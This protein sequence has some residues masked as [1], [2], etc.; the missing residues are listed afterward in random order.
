MKPVTEREPDGL[1]QLGTKLKLRTYLRELWSRRDFA[2][3]APLGDLRAQNMNSV[4]GSFWHLLNP[5]LLA[6]VYF[7][8]FGV[9]LG[10]RDDV[11]NFVAFLVIGIF[12]FHFTAKSLAGGS[13][14]VIA[15]LPL[16][17][18]MSFPRLVLPISAML[19]E[20]I[21]QVPAILTMFVIIAI[22]GEP[23][24]WLWLLVL[25]AFMLQSLF[26]F[27]LA[28][29]ISRLTFHFRDVQNLLPYAT[30]LLLYLSGVFYPAERIPAGT[31]RDLFEWNPMHVFIEVSRSLLLEQAVDP[32]YWGRAA[33]WTVVVAVAGFVF[34]RGKE[35]EY[36]RGY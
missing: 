31:A 33:L 19:T 12:I 11:P 25:P 32:V 22:T 23:I 20:A 27:G 6:G 24:T 9:I 16:M 1:V 36:G 5:L 18:S 13:R 14:A 28:C 35:N 26:N 15:N 3:T 17:Q 8:V 7:L 30:R 29:I 2:I 34:F 21:A 4:L 10:V